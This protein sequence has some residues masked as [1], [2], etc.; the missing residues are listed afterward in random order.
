[1][2]LDKGGRVLE[3]DTDELEVDEGIVV[4]CLGCG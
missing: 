3:M 1:M 4:S 2:D